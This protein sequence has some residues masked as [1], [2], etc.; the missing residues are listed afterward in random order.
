MAY[1]KY[2]PVD[3]Y[4]GDPIKEFIDSFKPGVDYTVKQYKSL[5]FNTTIIIDEN[6][7]DFNQLELNGWRP[8]KV[9]GK[10]IVSHKTINDPWPWFKMIMREFVA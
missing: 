1:R 8:N 3:N 5:A 9:D 7:A 10:V 2:K 4:A 6:L